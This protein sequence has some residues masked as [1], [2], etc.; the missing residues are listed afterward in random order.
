MYSSAIT[1]KGEGEFLVPLDLGATKASVA[2][3]IPTC[4]K[5]EITKIPKTTKAQGR[6]KDEHNLVRTKPEAL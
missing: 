4:N 3:R 1:G 6:E 5:E 2:I